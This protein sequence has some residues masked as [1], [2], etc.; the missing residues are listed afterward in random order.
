MF[1]FAKAIF[2]CF[3]CDSEASF[4]PSTYPS[5]VLARDPNDTSTGNEF[6]EEFLK[7][8]LVGATA[9][10]KT[11]RFRACQIISEN[12][13]YVV[14]SLD[15]E[16][17]RQAKQEFQAIINDPFMRN[18]I[19]LVF[20]S[21]HDLLSGW[22]I[23]WLLLKME[24]YFIGFPQILILDANRFYSIVFVDFNFPWSKY[25]AATATAIADVYIWDG[26]KSMD[27]PP[28][29]T[30]LHRVKGKEIP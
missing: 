27:K 30:R 22:N 5:K 15:Q 23:A 7:F 11:A 16:R 10:N 14:D 13:I 28:V 12:R 18:A 9:A 6:L 4:F 26:K 25:W 21:K 29:A 3:S 19:I 20:A 8:L 24:H 17:I 2:I 1:H